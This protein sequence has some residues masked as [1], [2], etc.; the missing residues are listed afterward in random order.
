[1]TFNN[2]LSQELESESYLESLTSIIAQFRNLYFTD[3]VLL[4]YLEYSEYSEFFD[5]FAVPASEDGMQRVGRGGKSIGRGYLLNQWIKGHDAGIFKDIVDKDYPH[6]WQVKVDDR[7]AYRSGWMREIVEERVSEIAN[8]LQKYNQCQQRIAQLRREKTTHTLSQKRIIGCTTTAAAKY[9]EELQKAAPSIIIVEEAGE[10]LES[11]TLTALST[12]TKQLVLIGDHKQ[13][14]PKVNNYS[15]TVEKGEGY[16]LNQSLFERLVVAGV[17]HT[18]LIR[19]HRMR[20]QISAYVRSLTY[21]E[22]QDA[23]TT[24]NRPQ[25]RGLQ[26]NVVFISHDHPELNANPIAD[27]RDEGAK[28]SKENDFEVGMVLKFVRYLGQQGYGTNDLVILTPYLG[29]LYRLMKTLSKENDPILNDLDSF[30]LMRAGLLSPAGANTSKRK[31][32]I[33]TIGMRAVRIHRKLTK[34][35]QITIRVKKA[36]LSLQA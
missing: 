10:I 28:A 19:Q 3:Q 31:I 27:S 12:N 9:T 34:K 32:K 6:I 33:S 20:P 24:N 26:D 11:H 22:L 36:I 35:A 14:R 2:I 5:A 25:L 8:L 23:P 15:L 7:L 29:Q 13:L 21:P 17:P 16:N 30:E 1:M 18:T 4:D